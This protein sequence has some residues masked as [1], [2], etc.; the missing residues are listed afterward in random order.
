MNV[1]DEPII[2]LFTDGACEG[3]PGPGGWGAILRYQS[4]TREFSGGFA[5]T[6]NNRMELCAVIGGLRAL[7]RHDLAVRVTSD[8]K[9]V[10]EAVEQGWLGKWAAKG[11]RKGKGMRENTDLWLELHRLL[12]QCR[13]RFVWIRGHQGHQENERCDQLAVAA[14]QQPNLPVDS[15]YTDPGT[16]AVTNGLSLL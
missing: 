10:T 8:S 14:R 3:N 5:H 1:T 6:T 16:A 4:H 2:E 9:Y 15:G 7:K 13:V 12:Q 11:F